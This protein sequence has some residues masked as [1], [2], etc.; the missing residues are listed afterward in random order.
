MSMFKHSLHHSGL[1]HS[2][3]EASLLTQLQTIGQQR[4][5]AARAIPLAA[6]TA[7]MEIPLTTVT[8]QAST[9]SLGNFDSQIDILFEGAPANSS[10]QL[11]LDSGN[12]TLIVPRFEDL[13]RLAGYTILAQNATEPW[14]CPAHIVR[15]P[16]DLPTRSRGILR[17]P[18]CVFYA[19]TGNNKNGER[20]SNF[21]L[22]YVTPWTADPSGVTIQAPLSYLQQLPF[23]Q[24]NILP[25]Q[26]ALG[27]AGRPS[28]TEDSTLT[29]FGQLPQDYRM[30]NTV[31][32]SPWM[33]LV[34]KSLSIG[35]VVT[36]WPGNLA[37]PIAMIDSGGGPVFLSD[38]NDAVSAQ[39]WPDTV[40]SPDWTNPGSLPCEST[41]AGIE[42]ELG[43]DVSSYTYSIDEA[44]LPASV[45][46]L[47]LV[48]C[49]QCEYMFGWNGMNVGGISML[50]NDLVIDYQSG[51]VG[52]KPKQA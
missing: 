14:G 27:A 52:L 37:S 15:G 29:L 49:K 16:I 6:P 4:F 32:N 11:M 12:T 13:S 7:G 50:V 30:F 2:V 19:C 43:D 35:G 33:A 17:I 22:G 24:V 20:T 45:K 10:V 47:T 26:D 41:A 36:A 40:R 1:R 9:A 44:S 51:R 46:G 5:S 42:I 28:V 8:Y 48:M 25:A 23:V 34:P 3:H 21:G 31:P 38:P 18:D 39:V